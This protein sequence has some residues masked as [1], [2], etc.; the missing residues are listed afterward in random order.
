[1]APGKVKWE[2]VR[3]GLPGLEDS[4]KRE[5]PSNATGTTALLLMLEELAQQL[6]EDPSFLGPVPCEQGLWLL[7]GGSLMF[8]TD[9]R[10]GLRPDEY[11]RQ[12]NTRQTDAEC[13]QP[14]Q[15]EAK[16]SGTGKPRGF[17]AD[18]SAP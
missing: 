1:M 16:A 14:Y 4:R 11:P 9:G 5:L 10:C 2:E 12:L 13:P 8:P 7:G 18:A 3:S 17:N 6:Y 15:R